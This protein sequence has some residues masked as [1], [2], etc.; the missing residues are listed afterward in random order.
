MSYFE[1][2]MLSIQQVSIR[3][4]LTK[5]VIRKWEDR[6]Q[7]VVP[8]RLE[9]GRRIYSERDVQILQMVRKLVEEGMN[10]QQATDYVHAHISEQP[11]YSPPSHL[12]D[13]CF[14]LLEEG[15]HCNIPAIQRILQ[16]AHQTLGLLAFLD[17]VVSPLLF[18]IG[19]RWEKSL[20][21]PFQ[22]SVSSTAIRDYLT[23]LRH[24]IRV[25]DSAPLILAGCL[26]GE[27]HDLPLCILLL[28]AQMKG[29]RGYLI[30]SSPAP[31]SI[32]HLVKQFNPSIVLLSAM[33]TAPFQ[34][35]PGSVEVLDEFARL[36][37]DI[38]FYMGGTGAKS[39]LETHTLHSITY[40]ESLESILR[41]ET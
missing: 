10:I 39:Y 11:G 16:E 35:H 12:S 20:W 7:T 31:G 33:S 14:R 17:E 26:P 28:K 37:P 34:L 23:G 41:E 30:A 8:K 19:Q 3:T 25:P 15:T 32:E 29:Y 5:P 38:R 18:E 21:N 9:N 40:K 24:Q 22:E 2:S 1:E 13:F 4:G 36:H 6:Y 27:V